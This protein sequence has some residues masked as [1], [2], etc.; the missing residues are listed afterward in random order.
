MSKVFWFDTETTGLYPDKCAIIQLAAIVEIDGEIVEELN[1]TIKPHNGALIEPRALEVNGRS[2][3]EIMG[4]QPVRPFLDDFKKKLA[5]YINKFDPEDKFITAGKN[6]DFDTSFLR[7][8]FFEAWGQ[9][10]RILVYTPLD[11]RPKRDRQAN[12]LPRPRA[13]QLQAG[14]GL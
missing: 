8:F 11:R 1:Y 13:P 7:A 6:V 12:G 2:E 10:L 9:V 5:Q 4:Y 14:H 3:G